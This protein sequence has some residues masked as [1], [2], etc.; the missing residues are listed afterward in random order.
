[1]FKTIT[2]QQVAILSVSL[3]VAGIAH[4]KLGAQAGAVSGLCATL[5]AFMLGRDATGPAAF[6]LVVGSMVAALAGLSACKGSSSPTPQEIEAG[7][8]IAVNVANGICQIVADISG[9]DTVT[10]ICPFL[11]STGQPVKDP[12]GKPKMVTVTLPRQSYEA[13][14]AR[15]QDGGK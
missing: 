5:I 11:D 9:N 1:M 14:R 6:F 8:P 13:M 4:W 10:M 7:I 3:L 2:W 15:Q 12:S